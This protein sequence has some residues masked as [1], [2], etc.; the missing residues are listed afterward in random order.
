MAEFSVHINRRDGVVEVEGSDKEWVA[1]QLRQL[2]SVYEP[3]VDDRPAAVVPT[4]TP[5]TTAARSTPP[6]PRPRRAGRST[7]GRARRNPELA[8]AL[9]SEVRTALQAYVDER[10][11]AWRSQVNQAAII[12]AFL[13]D[14]LGT[15]G[16]ID[17]DS[18][19]TVYSIMGWP[20]PNNFR[21]QIDNALR[22]NG[23]FGG[24]V[25]GRVQLSHSGEQFGR[26]GSRASP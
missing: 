4:P 13:M 16:W 10:Q 20:L 18:L 22:R 21:A 9:T 23:F 1:E 12:A 25:E 6:R 15:D 7:S 2:A 14:N 26:H 11:A 19:Y 17:E 24:W 3:S 8:Q 5:V